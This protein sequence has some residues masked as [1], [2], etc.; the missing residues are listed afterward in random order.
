MLSEYHRGPEIDEEDE[1]EQW[2]ADVD[3]SHR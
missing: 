2:G 3:D 1:M